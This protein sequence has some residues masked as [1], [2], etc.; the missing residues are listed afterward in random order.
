MRYIEALSLDEARA[1]IATLAKS[2]D[3]SLMYL[4]EKVNAN[5]NSIVKRWTKKT[6]AERRR[7]LLEA[8]PRIIPKP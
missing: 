4:R 1:S 5:G 3:E 6:V 7:L 8:Y 2:I